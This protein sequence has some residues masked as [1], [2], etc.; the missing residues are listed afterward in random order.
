MADGESGQN[1]RF[2][3]SL[4]SEKNKEN[5]ISPEAAL[6]IN[7]AATSYAVLSLT[8]ANRH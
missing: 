3:A 8:G 6:F 1:R 7:D 5:H 4:L 2:L